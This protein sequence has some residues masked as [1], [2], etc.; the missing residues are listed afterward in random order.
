VGEERTEV[1]FLRKTRVTEKKEPRKF[2]KPGRVYG[3][4]ETEKKT[5]PQGL[6]IYISK[7]SG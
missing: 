2:T 4:M 1:S 3:P 6:E 5:H 7:K